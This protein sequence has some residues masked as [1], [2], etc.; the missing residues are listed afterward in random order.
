MACF[1]IFF[2]TVHPDDLAQALIQL[3]V[4]FD[5]ALAFSMATRYLPTMAQEAQTIVDAQMSRGLELQKGNIIKRIRN[6]IPILI[7]LIISS[8]RR[9]I[10]VAESLESRAFGSTGKRTYL[11][12]L[13]I[14]KKDYFTIFLV[15]LAAALG[16][17]YKFFVGFPYW[18]GWQIPL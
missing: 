9:A 10:S 15:T 16:I 5:Y 4:P 13:K 6:F 2:L 12:E 14:A 7:P 18:V 11:H 3:H 1:S 8:V 17:Y